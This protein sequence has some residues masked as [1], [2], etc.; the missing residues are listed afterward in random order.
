MEIG[1]REKGMLVVLAVCIL[2]MGGAWFVFHDSGATRRDSSD[3]PKAEVK[4][5]E[6]KAKKSKSTKRTT[7]RRRKKGDKP[8]LQKR[9]RDP[10]ER[11]KM[12]KKTRKGRRKTKEKKKKIIPAA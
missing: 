1:K 2:G 7:S 9:Q 6:T 4:V 8:T 11:K 3:A 10:S 5:R 12:D